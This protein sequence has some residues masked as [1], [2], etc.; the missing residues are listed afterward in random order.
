MLGE[1]VAVPLAELAYE[2]RGA[3]DVGEQEGVRP[4]QVT[5][6]LACSR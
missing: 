3:F 6:S 1:H 4:G 2:R 5:G